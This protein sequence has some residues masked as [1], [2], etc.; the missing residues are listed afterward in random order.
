[1]KIMN[2]REQSVSNIRALT[3]LL[4][5]LGHSIII[6]SN[7]WGLYSTEKTSVLFD[8][9]K[10]YINVIQMPIF[11][12]V[13]GYLLYYS[14]K[15]GKELSFMKLIK[16]KFY[17]LLVPFLTFSLVWLLPIR[18]LI[19]YPKYQELNLWQ[20]ITTK[21]L[22]L[23]D[24]GHL[25]FLPSLFLMFISAFFILRLRKLINKQ[26]VVIDVFICICLLV[27][28]YLSGNI[29]IEILR[30][31]AYYFCFFIFGFMINEYKETITS[32][33]KK[34][35]I[36]FIIFTLM[37]FVVSGRYSPL[38]WVVNPALFTVMY[39]EL[40]FKAK[41]IDDISKNSFGIYLFHSPLCYI[42]F[43]FFSEINPLLMAF[44]NF[45]LFGAF[46]FLT[47]ALLRKTPLKVI[48]GEKLK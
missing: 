45:V 19:N 46:S 10:D 8:V 38:G 13:S 21:I 7:K 4:V 23:Q 26:I 18:M 9:L 34:L 28:S 36:L 47:T 15:S 24:I 14:T 41:F 43:A 35:R 22:S 31:T 6:Y 5:V 40:N 16:D 1:M 27:I 29:V 11:F 33:Y 17:R 32:F 30:Q 3:I 39:F 44:V 37:L 25:W 2:V 42:S 12:M 20:I 48:L